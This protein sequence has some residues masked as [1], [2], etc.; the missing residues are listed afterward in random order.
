M[1]ET[2][3]PG[4]PQGEGS[5]EKRE[6]SSGGPGAGPVSR[7]G[8][9][10]AMLYVLVASVFV[11]YVLLKVWPTEAATTGTP[12]TARQ[13]GTASPTPGPGGRSPSPSPTASLSPQATPTQSPTAT[14]SPQPTPAG[15][16]TPS[17]SPQATATLSPSPGSSPNASPSGEE[18]AGQTVSFFFGSYEI[19]PEMR[20][21]LIVMLAGALGSLVHGLRS[22][23]W[24]VGN[25]ELRWSWLAMYVLLPFVGALLAVVF[26]FVI[27]AGFGGNQAAT[28]HFGFA[29]FSA[30]IG[31][32]SEQAIQRLK[33]V[34]ETMLSKVDPGEDHKAPPGAATPNVLSV[35]PEEGGIA[36]ND[37]VTITGTNFAAGAKVSFGSVEA[38]EVK[39]VSSNKITAKTPAHAAGPVDVVV[40]NPDGQKGTLSGKFTYR[41]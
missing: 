13:A 33:L 16:L 31:L 40:T 25:R 39:F 41:Q 17:P 7:A 3:S 14:P 27:R 2:P 30:L 10:A 26:Y 11:L 19:P 35:A 1:S 21:L 28:G 15:S 29:A 36:G 32:F 9:A 20:L 8:I 18:Q 34:A 38:T 12:A 5:P 22:L 23:S 37:A 24:Y 4:T 6:D